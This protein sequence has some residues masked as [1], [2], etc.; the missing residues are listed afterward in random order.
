MLNPE[1]KLQDAVNDAYLWVWDRTGVTVSM[2]AFPLIAAEY[3]VCKSMI[4]RTPLVVAL[5]ILGAWGVLAAFR[6]MAQM[7]GNF[8]YC[9]GVATYWRPW[10]IRW[11]MIYPL[12]I[13]F[14]LQH[15][16][17]WQGWLDTILV[18]AWVNVW[19]CLVRE[20]KPVEKR[21]LI[22]SLSSS[23]S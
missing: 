5:V 11:L 17:A 6:H 12:Q 19:G 2:I 20:R 13:I 7:S 1:A 10:F 23:L 14:L 21:V 8:D 3:P 4:E 18:V 22:P 15:Y 16:A 9:N